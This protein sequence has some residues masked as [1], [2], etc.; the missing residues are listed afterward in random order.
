VLA[1][2]AGLPALWRTHG[3]LFL[4]LALPAATYLALLFLWMPYDWAS[5][6]TP[7]GRLLLPA[8]PVLLASL[9]PMLRRRGVGALVWVSLAVS[10]A[11][12]AFPSLRFN[13]FDGTDRMLGAFWGRFTALTEWLPSQVRPR[14]VPYV[15]W[16]AWAVLLTSLCI[17]R[18]GRMLPAGLMATALL[19]GLMSAGPRRSWEAED[20]P[21]DYRTLCVD[22]PAELDPS[23]RKHWI[24]TIERMLLLNDPRDAVMLPVAATDGET[25]EVD[26]RFISI[27]DGG[28]VPGLAVSCGASPES[29][30]ASSEHF[31]E[32]VLQRRD[33]LIPLPLTAGYFGGIRELLRVPAGTPPCTLRIVPLGVE[34]PH[35]PEHGIYLQRVEVR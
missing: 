21:P 6:P 15:V 16:T 10:A 33:S 20:I 22:Y 2:I 14:L 18:K 4:W 9:A 24:S 23:E 13:Y 29:L 12:I 32:E 34:P 30:Y 26:L 5:A 28:P 3:R 35:G 17:F 27:R 8:M 11:L 31:E 25:L 1:A 7:P 19:V